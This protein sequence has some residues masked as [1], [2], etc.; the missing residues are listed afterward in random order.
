MVGPRCHKFL[1][2][3]LFIKDVKDFLL[4]KLSL[5]GFVEKVG[6]TEEIL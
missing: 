5:K 3:R 4:G 2:P 1:G 6:L